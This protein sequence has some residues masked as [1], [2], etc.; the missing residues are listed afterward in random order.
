MSKAMKVIEGDELRNRR[1]ER[2]KRIREAARPIHH[3]NLEG[4]L[5]ILRTTPPEDRKALE[6]QHKTEQLRALLASTMAEMAHHDGRVSMLAFVD[7]LL[8][9]HAGGVCNNE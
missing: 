1:E 9:Q 2:D 8:L 7:G 5:H 6:R 4:A 3:S